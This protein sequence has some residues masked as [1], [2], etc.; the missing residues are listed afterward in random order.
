MAME[1]Q[2]SGLAPTTRTVNLT[3]EDMAALYDIVADYFVSMIPFLELG[4]RNMEYFPEKRAIRD[5]AQKY[6]VPFDHAESLANFY[7]A[8]LGRPNEQRN[9]DTRPKLEIA[10]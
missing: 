6:G 8:A 9:S 7:R 1:I 5:F 4:S 2:Y 3:E 10:K